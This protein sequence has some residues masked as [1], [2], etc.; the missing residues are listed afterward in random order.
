MYNTKLNNYRQK[1]KNST[2]YTPP[3]VSQFIFELLKDQ[4]DQ[5]RSYY[6][7]IFDPCVGAGSL[8]EPWTDNGYWTFGVEVD[9]SLVNCWVTL[10]ADFLTL[11]KKQKSGF[12]FRKHFK[13]YAKPQLVL[14]NPPF[15]GY[16][17]KLAPEVW[18]DKIIELFGKDIPIVLFVPAGFCLNLTLKSKRCLKFANGE[19]PPISSRITLPKNI[20]EGVVFHSEI[21]IFNI[22]DLQPHYFFSPVSKIEQRTPI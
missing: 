14:C 20:F 22:P 9:K 5:K 18:L 17:N 8:L 1:P 3:A 2:I 12:D 15:N 21:L 10:H 13:K 7:R 6:E 16:G 4:V 19:Y 11:D